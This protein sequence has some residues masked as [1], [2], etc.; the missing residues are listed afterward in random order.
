M[1]RKR[2]PIVTTVPRTL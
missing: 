1:E 2:S